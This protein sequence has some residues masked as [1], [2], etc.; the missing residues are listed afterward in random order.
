MYLTYQLEGITY[1]KENE[2]NLK[3]F[4]T[5]CGQDPCR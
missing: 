1:N 4:T 2:L 3:E 5:G